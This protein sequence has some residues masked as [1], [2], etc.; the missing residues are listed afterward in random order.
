V[1]RSSS[2]YEYIIKRQ[3]QDTFQQ[4]L[5]L[6]K[7]WN[8]FTKKHEIKYWASG[9]TLLGAI[10]HCGFIPWDNDIDV[11]I[12]LSDFEKVKKHLDDHETLSYFESR[13]G[14]KI[15]NDNNIYPF[16][17]IFICDYRDESKIEF[18]GI[19]TNEGKPTWLV[20][21]EFPRQHIYQDELFPLREV[22]FENT[23]IMVP[24][25]HKCLFRTFSKKCLTE[26]VVSNHVKNHVNVNKKSSEKNT[27]LYRNLYDL[28]EFLQL[29]Q[30]LRFT[31]YRFLPK[32]RYNLDND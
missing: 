11:C 19:L 1:N 7:L 18:C 6:L 31:H 32:R 8:D 26:C 16:L 30:I 22:E 14:I 3:E 13:F 2:S 29:P 17:D 23:T 20:A 5:N 4:L 24:N 25:I 10:R 15:Y 28:E 9:G 27:K 21:S 12:F